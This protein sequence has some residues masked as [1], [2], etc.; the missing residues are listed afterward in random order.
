MPALQTILRRLRTEARDL[1][2]LVLAPG[3]AALLP[4]P[5]CFRL[6]RRMAHWRFLYRQQCELALAQARQ[7]S[8]IDDERAWLAER[9]LVTLVDHAD[10]YLACTRSD[11]WLR[12]YVDV[13][14]GNDDGGS[15]SGGNDNG[16]NGGSNGNGAWGDPQAPTLLVTFHWA[17]GMWALRHAAAAGMRAHF[18]SAPVSGPGFAGRSVLGWYARARMRTVARAL[19][20][21]VVFRP[22]VMAQVMDIMQ[23]RQEQVLVVIDVPPDQVGAT[24][25]LRLLGQTVQ[26]PV[27]LQRLAVQHGWAVTVYTLGLDVQTGRRPLHLH[28]LGR[29]QDELALSQRIFSHFE[30]T[31]R[32]HPAAWHFWHVADRFF[33]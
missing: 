20:R 2:E 22:R 10:F 31:V 23:T 25:P 11:A 17:C 27:L 24:R 15:K 6:F 28:P 9:R 16:S 29:W 18:L 30:Q 32:S 5:L 1:L 8:Q 13:R 14:R 19:R 26:V 4:W 7:R 33:R 3:L 12:R 21:P